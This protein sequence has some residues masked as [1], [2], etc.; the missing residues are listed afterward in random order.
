MATI[1]DNEEGELRRTLQ[2]APFPTTPDMQ[3]TVR[4]LRRRRH[5]IQRCTIS[6]AALVLMGVGA[7][8]WQWQ[9]ADRIL[10]VR[11]GPAPPV[12]NG[13][14][15]VM[16]AALFTPPPVDSLNTLSRQQDAYVAVLQRMV[17]E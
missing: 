11:D 13:N 16:H 7:I 2:H 5:L 17:E 8:V 1:E 4:R 14:N 9:S 12:A 3:P 6:M 15:P 10:A